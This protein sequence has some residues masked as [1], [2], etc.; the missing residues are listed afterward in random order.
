MAAAQLNAIATAQ[1]VANLASA[2]TQQANVLATFQ[3]IS[4]PE[5]VRLF[6]MGDAFVKKAQEEAETTLQQL[7]EYF[8][9]FTSIDYA[10]PYAKGKKLKKNV[11][12]MFDRINPV[13]KKKVLEHIQSLYKDQVFL[14]GRRVKEGRRLYPFT[15]LLT[16]DANL[17]KKIATNK[18][19]FKAMVMA[20]LYN[21]K[22]ADP[23]DAIRHFGSSKG[24]STV[25]LGRVQ[26]D[27]KKY[28]KKY[29]NAAS[30]S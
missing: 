1:N 16:Q 7:Q 14:D 26:K 19:L 10:E 4:F 22:Y 23:K 13:L 6:S 12:F 29:R 3:S 8:K 27:K 30:Q 18:D 28:R 2:N 24:F 15:L 25:I 17:R 11:E 9:N 21:E 5:E 20:M